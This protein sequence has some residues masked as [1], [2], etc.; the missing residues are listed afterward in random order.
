M[1]ILLGCLNINGL[2]GSEM[3]HY[4]LA[5]EFNSAGH[6]VTIFTIR[7]IDYKDQVREKLFKLNIK[8][9]DTS[10]IDINESYDIIVAS[11]TFTNEF[12]VDH[13]HNTPIVDIIHSEIRFEHALYDS[14]ITHYI[15]IRP[16]IVNHLINGCEVVRDKTV[17]QGAIP[18]ENIT[19]IYNP[20]DTDRF[21]TDNI[22]KYK[23]TTGIFIGE[24]MDHIRVNAVNHIV[25]QSINND[26]DLLLMSN[27]KYD[28]KHPNIKYVE[29]NWNT[30]DIVK[31]CHFTAGI[32]LGRTT[33]EGLHCG[34]HGYMYMIDANGNILSIEATPPDNIVQLTDSKF[35]MQQHIELY[36]KI[37]HK[38]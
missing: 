9:V 2:G 24:V 5:R 13:F 20:I 32:L 1:K 11:Q 6:D 3:Y 33:L 35:V 16:S 38:I 34:I 10:T 30:E 18:K 31:K 14:R 29:K 28:F 25:E 36:N 19:L 8:Q 37:L 21:N 17:I 23:K 15:A 26:W 4:E 22:T 12:M 7:S 27:S